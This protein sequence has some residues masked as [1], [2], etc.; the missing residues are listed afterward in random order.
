MLSS[1]DR[2]KRLK[3]GKFIDELTSLLHQ[4]LIR[5]P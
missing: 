3:Y 1:M 2:W 5:L 4:V